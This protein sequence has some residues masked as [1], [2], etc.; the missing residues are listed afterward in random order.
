MKKILI[1]LTIAIS[2][3]GVSR[4]KAESIELPY[5]LYY[6]GDDFSNFSEFSTFMIES[7]EQSSELYR[8]LFDKYNSEYKTDYPYYLIQFLPLSSDDLIFNLVALEKPIYFERYINDPYGN[9]Y[10][11]DGSKISS[12]SDNFVILRSEYNFS[13]KEYIT[14]YIYRNSSFDNPAHYGLYS[15]FAELFFFDSNFDLKFYTDADN[16]IISNYRD[17]NSD[18]IIKSGDVYPTLYKYLFSLNNSYTEINLNDYAYV[19]L[20]LKDYNQDAFA[21]SVQVKGQYCI[22]PVYD[23]GLK[24][25]DSVTNTKVQNV[26]SPYYEN[27]TPVRTYITDDNLKN[28]AIYYVKSFDNTKDNYI[29]VDTDVFDISYITEENKDNPYVSVNGK[30]YLT[31]PYDE[32]PSSATQNTQEGYIPGQSEEFSFSDIFTAPLDFLKEIWSTITTFF[33]LITSFISLLPPI[34]QNFLY[35]SFMLAIALGLIKIIL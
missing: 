30:T 19:A 15:G 22:T 3:L 6:L 17:T 1:A 24:T 31:I 2:C 11:E 14:P 13:K 26:C 10:Y 16:I 5:T 33:T 28:N 23:F 32:L 21:T 27:Y 8:L 20:S 12:S 35:A 29:K 9:T 34:L 4:V 18:Y 7:E 25:Y